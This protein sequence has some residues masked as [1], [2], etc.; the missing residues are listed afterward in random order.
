MCSNVQWGLT[1]ALKASLKASVLAASIFVSGSSFHS[2]TVLGKK[3]YLYI[4]V[5]QPE[6]GEEPSLT[7]F[8]CVLLDIKILSRTISKL[9]K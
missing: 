5:L 7:D 6:F 3:L 4:L 9:G 8:H 2:L 1:W